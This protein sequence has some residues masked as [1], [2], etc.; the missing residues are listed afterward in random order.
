MCLNVRVGRAGR[1]SVQRPPGFGWSRGKSGV[2]ERTK[3]R[4]T[5]RAALAVACAASLALSAC[6]D[7]GGSDGGGGGGAASGGTI[8]LGYLTSLSGAASA[9]FTGL[10]GGANARL[11]SYKAE[12]GKCADTDFEV[13]MGDDTSS[14]QGALTAAQKLV[15]QDKVYAVLPNSSFFYGAG[16]Y[17]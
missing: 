5:N 11:E 1:L 13:V 7:D 8:K 12:G 9:G 14:P 6:G 3:M 17:A 2:E 15:Q 10:E 4:R 16:Q